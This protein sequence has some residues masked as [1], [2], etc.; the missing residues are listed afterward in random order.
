MILLMIILDVA[1]VGVWLGALKRLGSQVRRGPWKLPL[2][3]LG[4]G[5]MSAG[6]AIVVELTLQ[7]L[8]FPRGDHS[9]VGMLIDQVLMVGLVEEGCKFFFFL[10]F[11][12]R[13]APKDNPRDSMVLAAITALGFAGVENFIY[14]TSYGIGVLAGRSVMSTLS[15]MGYAGLWG[16]ISSSLENGKSRQ[17]EE[18]LAS[19]L[20][21]SGTLHGFS[22]LFIYLRMGG[23]HLLLKIFRD[24]EFC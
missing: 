21:F 5:V 18:A 23:A 3:F 2:Y 17:R 22:N 4:A 24:R 1:A 7:V 11:Y 14:G 16:Y 20:F 8:F 12:R 13:W 19:I 15:H 9:V 10:L 6:A